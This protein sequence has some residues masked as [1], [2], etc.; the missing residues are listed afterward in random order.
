M[1]GIESTPKKQRKGGPANDAPVAGLSILA[2][3]T[4]TRLVVVRFRK[5][6]NKRKKTPRAPRQ[7]SLN[8]TDIGP[9]HQSIHNCVTTLEATTYYLWANGPRQNLCVSLVSRFCHAKGLP[10]ILMLEDAP[11]LRVGDAGGADVA[12]QPLLPAAYDD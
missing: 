3:G 1:H 2:A 12:A 7:A 6:K 10:V 8:N 11:S 5:K 4:T 9:T